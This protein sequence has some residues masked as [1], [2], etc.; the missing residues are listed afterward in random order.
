MYDSISE[1]LDKI[2]LGEDT[3]FELKEARFSGNR[4][5]APGRDSLADELSAFAN[6]RGG[7]CMLGI[8]DSHEIIGIPLER[9]NILEDYVREIC[10]DS[11]KPQLAPVIERLFLPNETGEQVPVLK[12]E[13]SRSL[14][15]HQSP[16]GYFH[17]VGSAKRQISPEHLARL[18]Q[19]RGQTR[20][21][22]FDEQCVGNA[23]ITDLIPELWR[24]FAGEKT[25]G[26]DED[27]LMKLG[28]LRE[29]E[30]SKVRP[31]VAGILMGS[32]DPRPWLPNAF[33]QAVAYRGTTVLDNYDRNYQI[34]A[35]DITG[36]LDKQIMEACGF[37]RKNM[38]V[39]ARKGMGR[40]DTPQYD[41]T[42]VFEA[43]VNAVAH[44][45][46]SIYGSKVRLKMFTDR[47]EIYSPGTIPNTLTIEKLPYLQS[48]RNETLTSL[49][50]RCPVPE[51]E[52]VS[53]RSYIMDK[54]GDGVPLILSESE[55]LSGK[56]PVYKLIDDSELFLTIFAA[57][58]PKE[59]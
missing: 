46:Y 35:V 55:K 12:L 22:R 19:Q 26:S 50:S 51:Q 15:V 10:T 24:R 23:T 7:V 20:L 5:T 11:I 49:L 34:D 48:S 41:L 57:E 47:L 8:N 42:A 6:S 43:V 28:M 30:D 27:I 13:I 44:R 37:V 33:I 16:G 21:I 53:H 4:V 18:F 58:P 52:W 1:L 56:V 29:D 38:R 14:F 40:I 17:R 45:D 54:R 25:R 32:T 31:T 59:D 2:R 36:P 39:S 9:L 3:F